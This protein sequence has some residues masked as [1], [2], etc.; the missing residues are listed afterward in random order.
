LSQSVAD[1]TSPVG[2]IKYPARSNVSPT[3]ERTSESEI[4]SKMVLFGMG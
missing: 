1:P 3:T 4:K 2:K